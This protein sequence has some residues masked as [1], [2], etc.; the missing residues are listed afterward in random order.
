[1]FLSFHL[2]YEQERK[3]KQM[4]IKLKEE[5]K[6]IRQLK[7]MIDLTVQVLYQTEN[8]TL[9]EGLQHIQAARRYA[10]FLFPG[11]GNVFDLIY[12]PRL[13][14]ILGEKGLISTSNN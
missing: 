12:R 11:K 3:L 7:F 8:L 1:M 4:S 6:K 10:E 13:L 5:N 2:N 14:R 9:I